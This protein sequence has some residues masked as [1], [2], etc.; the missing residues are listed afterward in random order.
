M[1]WAC[2]NGLLLDFPFDVDMNDHTCHKAIGVPCGE[3]VLKLDDDADRDGK[4]LVFEGGKFL[5][6]SQ[7]RV[8]R[9]T[10]ECASVVEWSLTARDTLT[11]LKL[12]RFG[13]RHFKAR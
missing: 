6:V 3:G 9:R 1:T 7:L 8:P 5:E 11:V 13:G 2:K 10:A 4:V 12:L